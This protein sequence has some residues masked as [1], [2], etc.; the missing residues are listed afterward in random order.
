MPT[1]ISESTHRL[2]LEYLAIQLSIRDRKQIIQVLC[3]SS[4]DHVT[5][6]VRVAV[7]AYEPVIRNVHDAVDLSDSVSD[8]ESF[9]GDMLK[10]AKIQDEATIPTVGDFVALLKKHQ[11]SCH[12]F[13]HQVCKN[14]KEL[15]G[16]YLEWAKKAASQF[17]QQRASTE[18]KIRDAGDLTEPLNDLFSRLPTEQQEKLLP[19]LDQH[20]EH[21]DAM[22]AS[23]NR[24]LE[25]V[26]NS[27]P[28]KNPAIARIVASSNNSRSSSRA[29]SPGPGDKPAQAPKVTS[30]GPSSEPGPGA[31]LAR[32]QDLL[33]K[34]LITPL[35]LSG[36]VERASSKDVVKGSTK[37]VDGENLVEVPD[38]K[39]GAEKVQESV[40]GDGSTRTGK[41]EVGIVIEA[42]GKE[43][44]ALLGR[45]GV[46]W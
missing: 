39:T 6:A 8:F 33:D 31:Y 14:G 23:S 12:K 46:Y 27:A 5:A 13:I 44:R 36:K 45:R 42:M 17:R 20:S 30:S 3:H 21:I 41:P 4:P 35:S 15:T 1:D 10:V 9:L 38:G 43:F 7:S 22:H 11:Y 37:D 40:E 25:A 16:W 29:S 19:I 34:T 18:S 2:A 32:W 24:R 28:S 26:L